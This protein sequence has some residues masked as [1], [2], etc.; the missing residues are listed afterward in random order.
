MTTSCKLFAQGTSHL[1]LSNV[2][3]NRH[4]YSLHS[5]LLVPPPDPWH[6]CVC[7]CAECS[8]ILS[9]KFCHQNSQK[10]PIVYARQL[11]RKTTPKELTA[12]G[13]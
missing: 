8:G 1:V 7:V 6:M 10:Y 13:G 2:Y 12:K 9:D 4:Y 5:W 3:S 11:A